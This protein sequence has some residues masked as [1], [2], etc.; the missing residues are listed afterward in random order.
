MEDIATVICQQQLISEM[1]LP[2]KAVNNPFKNIFTIKKG[3][4]HETKSD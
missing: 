1:F 3:H 4:A 2:C